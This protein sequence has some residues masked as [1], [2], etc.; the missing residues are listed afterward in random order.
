MSQHLLYTANDTKIIQFDPTPIAAVDLGNKAIQLTGEHRFKAGERVTY[1]TGGGTAIGGLV[2]GHDYFVIP[3]G[4]SSFQLADAT[5]PDNLLNGGPKPLSEL[6]VVALSGG[7]TGDRHGFERASTA[8]RGD[9]AIDGLQDGQIYFVTKVNDT[10]IRLSDSPLTAEAALPVDLQ[11]PIDSNDLTLTHT[12]QAQGEEAGINVIASLESENRSIAQTRIGGTPTLADFLTANVAQDP[13]TAK[14]I[15][16]GRAGFLDVKKAAKFSLSASVAVAAFDHDVLAQVGEHAILESGGNITVNASAEQ[17][18][19][20]SAEGTVTSEALRPGVASQK[21]GSASIAVAVGTYNTTV[22][23]M[24]LGGAQL[25]AIGDIAVTS[26][27]SYPLLIDSLPFHQDRFDISNPEEGSVTDEL[28]S[29]LNGKLGLNNMMNVWAS[30]KGRVPEGKATITGSIGITSYTN[31]SEAIIGAGAKINQ[32]TDYKDLSHSVSVDAKTSME[33]VNIAGIIQLDM[34]PENLKQLAKTKSSPFSLFGNEAGMLG[35]GGSVLVQSIENHTIAK[36]EGSVV[37]D[38]VVTANTNV[39]GELSVTA[40]EDIWS[41]DFAQAGGNSGKIGVSGSFSFADHT[42]ETLAQLDSGVRHKGDSVLVDADS[43]VNYLNLVGAVQ[44]AKEVG[45]G[46]SVGS[47]TVGR[48]TEAVVGKRRANKNDTSIGNNGTTI[49]ADTL[50][51]EASNDG[52][53]MGIGVAAAVVSDIPGLSITPKGNKPSQIGIGI[54]GVYNENFVTDNTQ[55]YVNDQGKITLVDDLSIDSQDHTSIFSVSGA[56]TLVKPS[57]TAKAAVGLAGAVSINELNMT[58]EAFLAGAD[59]EGV[60]NVTLNA[61]R[62]GDVFALTVGVAV[63]ALT[64]P[65]G[66]A[67]VSAAGSASVNTIASTTRAFIDSGDIDASNDVSLTAKDTAVIKAVAI[68]GAGA[69]GSGKASVALA[70]A[71]SLNTISGGV[72]AY[73]ANSTA[74]TR[75]PGIK[76]GCTVTLTATDDTT[77]TADAGGFAIAIGT[78]GSGGAKVSGS[79]GASIAINDIGGDAPRNVLAYADNTTIE[80]GMG[81]VT[82]TAISTATINAL[83]IGGALSGTQ[84][85]AG[86]TGALAGAGVAGVNTIRTNV[87]AKAKD[88]RITVKNGNLDL[89]ASDTSTITAHS[90]G[91]SVALAQASGGTGAAVSIGVSLSLNEIDND[92]TAAIENASLVQVEAGDVLVSAVSESTIKAI[93]VAASLSASQG[94]T[95]VGVSGGGAVSTNQV[96]GRTN[97]YVTG[98]NITQV[99]DVDLDARNTSVVDATIAAVSASLSLGTTTGVGV[100]IGVSV[101]RNFIGVEVNESTAFNYATDTGLGQGQELHKNDK[102]KIADGARAGDVYEYLGPDRTQPTADYTTELAVGQTTKFKTVNPGDLVEVMPGFEGASGNVGSIYKY[103]GTAGSIDLAAA[104]YNTSDWEVVSIDLR[105]QDYSDTSLWK[106]VNLTDS[107]AQ[108][109]AYIENSAI[110]ATGDLTVDAIANQ[111]IDAKVVA[112]AVGLAGGTNTGVAVSGAGSYSENKVNTDIKA[113]IDGDGLN[114]ATDGISAD[115]VS[116]NADDSSSISAITAAASLAGAIS[117]GNLG[118]SVSIGLSIALNEIGNEVDAYIKNADQGVTATDGDITVTATSQGKATHNISLSAAN[119]T[120][121]NLDDAAK[122]DQDDPDTGSDEALAD[123]DD[124]AVILNKIQSAL[125]TALGVQLADNNGVSTASTFTTDDGTQE[126]QRGDTVRLADGSVYR[127]RGSIEEQSIDLKTTDY[128]VTS[129]WRKVPALKVSSLGEGGGWLAVDGEGKSYILKPDPTNSNQLTI[130]QTNINAVSAAASLA[131]SF[132]GTIG[133]AIS[134]AGAVAQNVILTN[135]N[136]HVEDSKLNSAGDLALTAA[137]TSN[138]TST[139]VAVSLGIGGSSTTGA[140]V[141]IGVAVA[142]NYIGYRPDGSE[143]RSQVRAYMKNVSVVADGDIIQTAAAAQ[144]IS[145]LVFAGSVGVGIGGSGIGI[146]ASGSGVS[147]E[148]RIGV[149]VKAFIDGDGATGIL[150]DSVALAAVDTSVINAFAG[151]VSLAVA[152]GGNVGVA[153][154]IGV[155]LAKNVISSDVG[156]YIINADQGVETTVGGIHLLADETATINA[157]SAAASLAAGFG[158]TGGIAVSGAGAE[159]KNIIL[160]KANAYVDGKYEYQRR[161]PG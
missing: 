47:T 159:A 131:A 127:Y 14:A 56:A 128:T 133:V 7:A 79:I 104:D 10:T 15:A 108:V 146:G 57:A 53:I 81:D 114:S 11:E 50:T 84:G 115:R 41:L 1:L 87:G 6:T 46:V 157:I 126:V 3:T 74:D 55:A 8:A 66:T 113:Y 25:D 86:F 70:G 73:I 27:V 123:A 88:S 137:S 124:D 60:N 100:A 82:L 93:A 129:L 76:T 118:V 160:T 101:A 140:G 143:P 155:S 65:T 34:R 102:V 138:I 110:T 103:K 21:I 12:L 91:A 61:E 71:V 119:L 4:D 38:G 54:A 152:F 63:A 158:G 149:D 33:L 80:A 97:A 58:T 36:I 89:D 117:G 153:V 18:V 94:M 59:V 44:L 95:S 144:N 52:R 64:S 116:L 130:A 148:N 136:A 31:V 92:V 39:N 40:S 13:K 77:I 135:T 62:D 75:G 120:V 154:S 16:S 83:A 161:F 151:A 22:Q 35:I 156:S 125:E 24:V 132:G 28:A 17:S 43:V 85:S 48:S 134:G 20:V 69:G 72:E 107:A 142:N 30:T 106:Q 122:A 98:S 42:S 68:G 147:T 99:G 32:K 67:A 139:V 109:Q 23:A 78:G 45:I 5:D 111:N 29:A 96:T 121:D 141:S 150:A 90:I 2:N 19:Q 51:L 105:T 112:V 9:T 49:D 145:S 37:V 26:D